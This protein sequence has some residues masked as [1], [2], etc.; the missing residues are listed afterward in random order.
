MRRDFSK[1]KHAASSS[2]NLLEAPFS[3][4]VNNVII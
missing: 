1:E 4:A 2:A 3:Q